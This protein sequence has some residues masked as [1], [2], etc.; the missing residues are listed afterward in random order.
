MVI[1]AGLALPGIHEVPKGFPATTLFNFREASVGIQLVLW[2][3][4]GLVFAALAPRVMAGKTIFPRRSSAPGAGR[5]QPGSDLRWRP[6]AA[7]ACA[8]CTRPRTG[9]WRGPRAGR[10]GDG[11]AAA[12]AIADAAGLGSGLVELT[13]RANLQLRGLPADAGPELVARMRG[14]GLLPSPAHDRVRNLLGSP[15]AGPERRRGAVGARPGTV[16]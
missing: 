12:R 15:L 3:T 9:P 13:S 6:T 14:A 8:S 10:A 7:R 5:R 2:T 4:V 16:R 11:R 1:V